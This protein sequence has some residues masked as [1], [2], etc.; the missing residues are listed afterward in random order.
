MTD[1]TVFTCLASFCV[2][3]NCLSGYLRNSTDSEDQQ[4]GFIVK[5]KPIELTPAVSPLTSVYIYAYTQKIDK[6][7]F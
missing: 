6:K 1:D 4:D 2:N 7:N 5:I 3:C